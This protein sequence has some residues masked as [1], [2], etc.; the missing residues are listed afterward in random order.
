MGVFIKQNF[1]F[2]DRYDVVPSPSEFE[3]HMHNEYELYFFLEGNVDYILGDSL[4]HL[5]KGDILLIRPAVFHYPKILPDMPYH[6]I[7]VNFSEEHVDPALCSD[8]AEFQPFYRIPDGGMIRKLYE[9]VAYTMERYRAEDEYPC[10]LRYLNLILTEL[11]YINRPDG[12]ES[13]PLHPLLSDILEYIDKNLSA[14]LSLNAIAKEFYVSPSWITHTFHKYMSIG[15]MQ[16]VTKKR[17]LT[18]QQ[19]IQKGVPPTEA[20]EC[21]GFRNYSTF[22]L[23]Y[24]KLLG[25][26]PA[27]DKK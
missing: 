3:L 4:Y 9:S 27:K 13:A 16:Y 20:A 26:N 25:G 24:K 17:I 2:Q 21:C 12:F 14:E 5:Q 22:Y 1:I 7:Y 6:R 15:T 19:L 18:S 10:L 11:K 23:Q 8:L